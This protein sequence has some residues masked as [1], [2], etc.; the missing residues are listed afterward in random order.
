MMALPRVVVVRVVRSD[1]EFSYSLSL[2]PPP[3]PPT[4]RHTLMVELTRL[5]DKL[6]DVTCE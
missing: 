3:P 5:A 4:H 2:S 6:Q 1:G